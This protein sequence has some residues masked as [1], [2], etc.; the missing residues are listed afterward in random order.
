MDD[1]DFNPRIRRAPLDGSSNKRARVFSTKRPRSDDPPW[2]T[3]SLYSTEGERARKIPRVDYNEDEFGWTFADNEAFREPP[4]TGRAEAASMP[5]T[6]P[7]PP[8]TVPT[9]FTPAAPL[10][11][12]LNNLQLTSLA[13]YGSLLGFL[14]EDQIRNLVAADNGNS[15]DGRAVIV[16]RPGRRGTHIPPA[17]RFIREGPKKIFL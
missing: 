1:D 3:E 8:G 14:S 17:P 7:P 11:P 13:P 2:T 9:P 10:F 15:P 4:D 16:S 5:T 6:A 12:G